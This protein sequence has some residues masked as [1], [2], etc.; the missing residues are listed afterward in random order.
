MNP[1]HSK[2]YPVLKVSNLHV[3][4]I[5]RNRYNFH[6]STEINAVNG[7]SFSVKQNETFAIVGE[8]GSGKTSI[9]MSILRFVKPAAG[10]IFFKDK[11]IWQIGKTDLQ[12]LRRKIQPVFQDSNSSLNP[13]MSVGKIIGEGIRN[14]RNPQS[15]KKKT[16]ELLKS[17]GLNEEHFERFSHQL[18]GG[19]KQR[20]CIARALAPKP[21]LLILDEPVSS[22][23]LSIQAHIINLLLD[24]KK[25]Y[26]LTYLLISHDLQVVRFLADRIAV[27][28][29]GKFVELSEH[30]KIFT[31]PKHQYTKLLFRSSGIIR[32][33]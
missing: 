11:D 15:Q 8:S 16:I 26:K 7:I 12:K 4:Y 29:Q 20:V 14:N 30:N 27:M 3:K 24:L 1:K 18:S 6:K 31:N 23:D 21:E 19:Q 17:V 28:K 5:N 13:R 32:K 33:D 9:A 2:D 22:Q 10:N 25:K